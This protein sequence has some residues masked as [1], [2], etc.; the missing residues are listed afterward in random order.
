MEI[1]N[2]GP[3]ILFRVAEGDTLT[4]E[5]LSRSRTARWAKHQGLTGKA[6]LEFQG[7]DNDTVSLNVFI[8][9]QD[10]IRPQDIIEDMDGA[11]ARGDILDLVIGGVD[12]GRFV[13]Q[14]VKLA[15]SVFTPSGLLYSARASLSLI[16]YA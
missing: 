9:A 5:G 7:A 3:D 13:L 4:F 10:D 16:E 14:S 6:A 1:G 12:Y 11:I 2:L 8:I 15:D